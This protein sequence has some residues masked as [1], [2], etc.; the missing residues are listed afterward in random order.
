MKYRVKRII[1][2]ILFYGLLFSGAVLAAT[3]FTEANAV[4]APSYAK[5]ELSPVV[6]KTNLSRADYSL[7][8]SQ[9]GLGRA[10]ID[11]IWA[12]EPDIKAVLDAYQG[13]FFSAPAVVCASIAGF[14]R[15][16]SVVEQKD[17][18]QIYDLEAGDVL[19]TKSTHTLCYRHGHSSLYLGNNKLLEATVIG[20]PVTTTEAWAWGG[21]PT[22]IQLRISAKAA[23]AVGMTQ[24]QLGEAVAAYAQ[25]ELL[26]DNY[27]LLTGAFGVGPATNDTQCADLIYRAFLHF[28][29]TV[30]TR[31]F[32][33][34]PSSLLKSGM[35][36]VV[37]VW[38]MDPAHLRW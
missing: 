1:Y 26:G 4:S 3:A 23:A 9:T 14:S 29:V 13:R 18:Y 38:G 22:G 33:V 2:F 20:S 37:Q 6:A 28:G 25:E 30:S 7:L 31:T 5:V 21:Y 16:E 17:F 34:T 36:E 27:S 11:R 8:L 32:P 12:T 19:L 24:A 10:D 35:F 15:A